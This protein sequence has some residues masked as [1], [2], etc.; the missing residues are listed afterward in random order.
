M[1]SRRLL[2]ARLTSG[3][4]LAGLCA[5]LFFLRFALNAGMLVDIG[6]AFTSAVAQLFFPSQ[7][8]GLANDFPAQRVTVLAWNNSA[9]FL[10][11]S[12]GSIVGG[13]AIALGGFGANLTVSAAIALVGWMINSA[14]APTPA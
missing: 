7:Q 14:V 10:G 12:L 11:I 9:L 2:G 5:S 8:A 1:L 6:L 3:I 13:Q 4:S